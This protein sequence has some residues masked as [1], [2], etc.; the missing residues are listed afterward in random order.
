[1]TKSPFLLKETGTVHLRAFAETQIGRSDPSDVYAVRVIPNAPRVL[2]V[3][4]NDRWQGDPVPEN[5][6]GASHAFVRAYAQ[7]MPDG[8][9][10]DTCP[11]EKVSA[12]SLLAWDAVLWA[13]AEDSAADESVSRAEADL[14]TSYLEANGSLFVSGAEIAWDLDP[15]GNAGSTAADK[16]FLESMLKAR[17]VSDDAGT[18]T[19]EGTSTGIF[20]DR[21]GEKRLSFW[22]PGQIFVAY[23]DVLS[24][25]GG[26]TSCLNYLGSTS[27]ACVQFQGEYDLVYFGFPFESI[28]GTAERALVLDRV[29][30]HLGLSASLKPRLLAAMW[31]V[32]RLGVPDHSGAPCSHSHSSD[33]A[34]LAIEN[35]GIL[36]N[37][38]GTR[39]E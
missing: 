33:L 14:L 31:D 10:F 35:H 25:L 27:S 26:A 9:A 22:T 15:A 8:I 2:I 6:L 36:M 7:A 30:Q 18:Y 19:V 11:D 23:P 17:Y 37:R 16:T 21:V 28:D 20:A 13:A 38:C 1:V 24:P 5:T 3:D 34:A 29:L 32:L 4:A 39:R 12:Q